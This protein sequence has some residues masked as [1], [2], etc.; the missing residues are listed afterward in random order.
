MICSNEPGY[1]K[2]GHFGIRT[3]NLLLVR[4]AE[5]LL[6]VRV[7]ALLE[8]ARVVDLPAAERVVAREGDLAALAQAIERGAVAVVSELQAPAGFGGPWIQVPHGRRTLAMAS[9]PA[10]SIRASQ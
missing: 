9:A 6:G 7:L 1:Y 2:P 8:V 4:E 5:G 3:E 10:A